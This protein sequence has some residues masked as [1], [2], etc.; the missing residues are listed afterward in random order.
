MNKLEDR[1]I[2]THLEIFQ[3]TP[4]ERIRLITLTNSHVNGSHINLCLFK[5]LLGSII[6]YDRENVFNFT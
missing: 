2:S 1:I 4:C 6:L 3:F 5:L